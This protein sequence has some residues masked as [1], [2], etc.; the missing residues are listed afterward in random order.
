MTYA[1][2]GAPLYLSATCYYYVITPD[3]YSQTPP[4][5]MTSILDL[6]FCPKPFYVSKGSPSLHLD[7]FLTGG[8]PLCCYTGGG[9]IIIIA[10]MPAEPGQTHM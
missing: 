4:F 3:Y 2:S 5:S 7:L 10:C 6:T 1:M 8:L 9:Y